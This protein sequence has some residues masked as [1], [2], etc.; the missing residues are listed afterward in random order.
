MKR[1][2]NVRVEMHKTVCDAANAAG[3]KS[4]D[5]FEEERG[6]PVV[7]ER[8]QALTVSRTTCFSRVGGRPRRYGGGVSG[9]DHHREARDAKTQAAQAGHR[10]P[11]AIE[12]QSRQDSPFSWQQSLFTLRSNSRNGGVVHCLD[13]GGCMPPPHFSDD[14]RR[15]FRELLVWRRDVR[16]FRRQPIDPVIFGELIG[17]ACL[18]PSVG[19]SQPWRFVLVEDPCAA[20]G[21]AISS[22]AV[23]MPRGQRTRAPAPRSTV[24]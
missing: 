19:N 3:G 21:S 23:T 5:V 20:S 6:R 13:A 10:R 16:R 4:E 18:A 15:Q 12:Y 17:L 7:E 11:V 8:T 1:S 14:F 22:R 24:S 2:P 9:G